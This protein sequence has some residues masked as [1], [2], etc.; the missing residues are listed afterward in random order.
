MKAVS[1]GSGEADCSP[2]GGGAAVRR[3]DAV[4]ADPRAPGVDLD[5]GGTGEGRG[6]HC[7]ARPTGRVSQ[8]RFVCRSCGF[9]DHA[10]RNSSRN[11]RARAWALWRRGAQSTA[12]DL[13]AKCPDG[14][15]RKRRLTASDD[16]CA[17]PG[18]AAPGG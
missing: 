4:L 10:D 7:R 14:T 12:P 6:V 16:R 8:A 15:G 13:P 11:I 18:P 17:S 3:P 5:G 2:T 1:A 9:V